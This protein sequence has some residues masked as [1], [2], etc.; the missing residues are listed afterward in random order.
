MTFVTA[1]IL[2]DPH[3]ELHTWSTE[4][5]AALHSLQFTLWLVSTPP[6]TS[7]LSS[8]LCFKLHSGFA[9]LLSTA[10][11]SHPLTGLFKQH[12][13]EHSDK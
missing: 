2:E 13:L 5:D 6:Q 10:H 7:D 1:G 3:Q 4:G 12:A 8:F 9:V 11:I